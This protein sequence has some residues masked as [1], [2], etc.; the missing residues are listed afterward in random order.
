ML[1]SGSRVFKSQ[2]DFRN[3]APHQEERIIPPKFPEINAEIE[4][5]P[6]ELHRNYTVN[7]EGCQSN[8]TE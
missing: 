7:V 4:E 8:T 3:P 6:F 1:R 5:V 2:K